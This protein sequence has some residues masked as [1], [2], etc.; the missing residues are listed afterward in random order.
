[1]KKSYP[2]E[3]VFQLTS[4]ILAI[5]LVL[6]LLLDPLL[7]PFAPAQASPEVDAETAD[8]QPWPRQL[9]EAGAKIEMHS[10]GTHPVGDGFTAAWTNDGLLVF[11]GS[12]MYRYRR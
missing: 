8:G 5:L 4:L 1:M 10:F 2:V 11:D 6:T 12:T 3:F 9:T 7:M